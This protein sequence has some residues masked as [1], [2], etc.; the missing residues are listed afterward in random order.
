MNPVGTPIGPR[1][2]KP[3]GGAAGPKAL[4]LVHVNGYV[5]R[6]ALQA[7][8]VDPG[9]LPEHLRAARPGLHPADL[10]PLMPTIND[11]VRHAI[12]APWSL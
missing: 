2:G 8:G 3:R 10:H 5:W 4:T 7:A 6:P 9:V 1:L 11:A 12:D